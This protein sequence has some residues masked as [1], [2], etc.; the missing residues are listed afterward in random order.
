MTAR[1][2][3]RKPP[4]GLGAR[5]RQLWRFLVEFEPEQHEVVQLLECCRIVDRLD[6]L[7]EILAVEGLGATNGRGDAVPHWALVESRQQT[8]A[9]NRT[10][11]ALRI[12]LP[13]G[14][15][16]WDGLSS[17]ARA[18]RAALIRHHGGGRHA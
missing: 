7:A 14:Q 11:S 6:A 12:P 5:G 9:L 2:A 8:L 3:P 17:S 15:D 13:E 1:K 16:D 10:L 18:R 4:A